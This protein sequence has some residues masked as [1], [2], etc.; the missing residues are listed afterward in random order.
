[1]A[2]KKKTTTPAEPPCPEPALT[3]PRLPGSATIDLKLFG[4]A[5]SAQVLIPHC[6]IDNAVGLR[7]AVSHETPV[8]TDGDG[9]L[10]YGL[11]V[12]DARGLRDLL[13]IATARG[14]L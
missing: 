2:K 5:C 4:T 1:M 13:N 6:T 3:F 8:T 10:I 12:D 11:P 14:V 9:V 7:L